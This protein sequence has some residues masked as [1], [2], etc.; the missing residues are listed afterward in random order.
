MKTQPTLAGTLHA[1]LLLFFI[2]AAVLLGVSLCL[3]WLITRISQ[4]DLFQASV[5]CLIA[6]AVCT[7][8]FLRT[9]RE[10]A[11]GPL[12]CDCHDEEDDIPFD[13]EPRAEGASAARGHWIA[14]SGPSPTS[15]GAVARTAAA[16]I[17]TDRQAASLPIA[18]MTR[19]S[20]SGGRAPAP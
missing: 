6:L 1:I 3:G 8:H 5:L 2:P 16:A 7:V 10:M 4:F 17:P 19:V 18:G 11:A 15:K 9:A 12:P 20:Q 14:T 13:S